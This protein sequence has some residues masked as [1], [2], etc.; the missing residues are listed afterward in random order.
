MYCDHGHATVRDVRI[1]PLGGGANIYVCRYHY[2]QEMTFRLSRARHTEN[3]DAWEFPE[4]DTL[5]PIC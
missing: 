4:W 1:L 2:D 3:W 5:E